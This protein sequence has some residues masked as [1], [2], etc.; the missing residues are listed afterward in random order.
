MFKTFTFFLTKFFLGFS[1][2]F[3]A[4]QDIPADLLPPPRPDQLD[5]TSHFAQMRLERAKTI[6][7]TLIPNSQDYELIL[8]S[9]PSIGGEAVPP[10][11]FSDKPTMIL[12]QGTLSPDRSNEE[13]AFVMAHE[14]GHLELG[15]HEEMGKLMDEIYNGNPV[16]LSGTTFIPYFQKLQEQQADLF[17]LNLYK[18][19]HYD[20][21]FFPYTLRL[22]KINPNIHYGTNMPFRKELS[23]LSMNNTHFSMKE[24]FERLTKEAQIS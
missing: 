2:A 6:L 19:A 12:Y 17:G 22:I 13:I 16:K 18:K 11:V 20:L 23:S 24:R 15:H 5:S 4:V 8:S 10:Y 14:L 3:G 7:A 21:N 9:T 1:L